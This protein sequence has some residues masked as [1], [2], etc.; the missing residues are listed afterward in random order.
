VR[1]L[2]L[3]GFDHLEKV[4]HGAGQPIEPHYDEDLTWLHLT[5]EPREHRPRPAR[6]RA[7]LLMNLSTTGRTQF[8]ELGVM[9]LLLCRDTGVAEHARFRAGRGHEL[10][11]KAVFNAFVHFNL[12]PATDHLQT[13]FKPFG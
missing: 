13:I 9:R 12:S 1:L 3:K 5:N 7:V 8:V 10:G 11:S 6:A 4:A 2:G